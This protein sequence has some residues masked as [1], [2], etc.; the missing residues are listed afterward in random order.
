M[1]N[2]IIFYGPLI[3]I[4]ILIFLQMQ[5]AKAIQLLGMQFLDLNARV[6]ELEDSEDGLGRQIQDQGLKLAKHLKQLH[7]L[8]EIQ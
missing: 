1:L 7:P 8:E 6:K 3:T 2:Y 4:C 5:Q